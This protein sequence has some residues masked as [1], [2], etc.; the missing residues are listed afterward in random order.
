M[1]S[2]IHGASLKVDHE[3][4]YFPGVLERILV[5]FHK[6]WLLPLHLHLEDQRP[7]R[8]CSTLPLHHL[9]L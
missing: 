7:L 9:L 1:K 2:K 8:L 3:R 6:R 5:S 4:Q